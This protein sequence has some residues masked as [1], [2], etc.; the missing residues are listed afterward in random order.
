[1]FGYPVH[2]AHLARG[3]AMTMYTPESQSNHCLRPLKPLHARV[4]ASRTLAA[5]TVA[6][7]EVVLGWCSKRRTREAL[8]RRDCSMLGRS[9][10]E[11]TCKNAV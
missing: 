5:C 7:A 6:L 2:D 10:R 1:M 11:L 3:S 9:Q 8:F 4:A